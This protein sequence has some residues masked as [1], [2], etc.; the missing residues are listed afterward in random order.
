MRESAVEAYCKA[1]A[2]PRASLRSRSSHRSSQQSPRVTRVRWE[3]GATALTLEELGDLWIAP[4][5]R[6]E[7]CRR[8]RMPSWLTGKEGQSRRTR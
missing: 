7:S 1:S 3:W 8:P 5:I 6:P 4:L 2:M